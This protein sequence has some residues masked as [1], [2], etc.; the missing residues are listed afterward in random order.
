MTLEPLTCIWM[1]FTTSQ[2]FT[3]FTFHLVVS[4]V[5]P[6]KEAFHNVKVFGAQK[7]TQFRDDQ[8]YFLYGTPGSPKQ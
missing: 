5:A 6:E 3:R 7:K 8:V 1:M 2:S 4:G